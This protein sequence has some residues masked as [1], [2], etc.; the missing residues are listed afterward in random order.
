MG[1]KNPDGFM[2][3]LEAGFSLAATI[4]GRNTPDG[5]RRRGLGTERD[6]L[7]S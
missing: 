3:R 6:R 5:K 1:L 4:N 2:A 7:L